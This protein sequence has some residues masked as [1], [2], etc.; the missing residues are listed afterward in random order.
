[1]NRP[2]PI[3]GR[4]VV[5]ATVGGALVGRFVADLVGAPPWIGG[6][7]GAAAPM[8]RAAGVADALPAPATTAIR[9]LAAPGEGIG[10]MMYPSGLQLLALNEDDEP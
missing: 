6:I 3:N 9:I 8:V 2:D 4:R 10:R 1:M 5:V 7:L